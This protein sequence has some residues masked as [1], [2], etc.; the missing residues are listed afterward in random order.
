MFHLSSISLSEES[1]ERGCLYFSRLN[2]EWAVFIHAVERR[3][4]LT[5][6]EK[7]NAG[8][9]QDV[10]NFFEIRS[11]ARLF[12]TQT[13]FNSFISSC[14]ELLC[15][16]NSVRSFSSRFSEDDSASETRFSSSSTCSRASCSSRRESRSF[17]STLAWDDS[18]SFSLFSDAFN[19]S[20]NSLKQ[21]EEKLPVGTIEVGGRTWHNRYNGEK[22]FLMSWK[23]LSH[24]IAASIWCIR[25]STS[26]ALWA[27]TFCSCLLS[28]FF[29]ALFSFW[30]FSLDSFKAVHCSVT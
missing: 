16:D 3:I 9:T 24:L 4:I 20:S 7:L 12:K 2:V 26:C 21:A 15:E 30:L 18:W 13:F 29:L 5:Y 1:A 22:H 8:D 10:E 11:V 6:K 19:F 27:S 14:M 25:A 17:A 28:K 23:G